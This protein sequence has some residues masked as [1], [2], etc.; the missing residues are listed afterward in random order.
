[1]NNLQFYEFTGVYLCL[2]GLNFALLADYSKLHWRWVFVGLVVAAVTTLTA[3]VS[4][5]IAAG[6]GPFLTL[7]EVIL[8]NLFSVTALYAFIYRF[9]PAARIGSF[10]VLLVLLLLGGWSLTLSTEVVPLPATFDNY[11]L[12][13]HVITGKLFLAAC[14]AGAGIASALLYRQ[15]GLAASDEAF[16]E[17]SDGAIWRIMSAAFVAHSAMLLS[18]AVWAYDAWGRYWAWDP[19]ETWVFITWLLQGLLLHL[20]VTLKAPLWSLWLLVEL[21]FIL[22]FITFFGVPFLSTT[23]HAGVM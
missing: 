3:I 5:W 9:S 23:P 13:V 1:M 8:S 6:Q 4:R 15:L 16:M 20:R 22:A 14:F 7:Y 11:W 12:W 18:G 10:P 2:A 21:V 17:A 19:L